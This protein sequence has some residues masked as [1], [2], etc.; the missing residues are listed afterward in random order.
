MCYLQSSEFNL[1]NCNLAL[2]ILLIFDEIIHIFYSN[3]ICF[4]LFT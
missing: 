1:K 4:E 3:I 2:N